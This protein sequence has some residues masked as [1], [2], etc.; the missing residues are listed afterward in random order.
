LNTI[1]IICFSTMTSEKVECTEDDASSTS[2]ERKF[3][4]KL[5]VVQ[6]GSKQPD[7]L[8]RAESYFSTAG[9][10]AGTCPRQFFLPTWRTFTAIGLFFLDTVVRRWIH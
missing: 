9:S 8:N 1:N 2:Q 5:T 10:R 6:V 4:V 7:Q 3:F